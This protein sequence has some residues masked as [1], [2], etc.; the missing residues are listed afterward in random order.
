V[1]YDP[2]VPILEACPHRND[3]RA[4]IGE[5]P[6]AALRPAGLSPIPHR[7]SWPRPDI[8]PYRCFP[9]HRASRWGQMRADVGLFAKFGPEGAVELPYGCKGIRAP[10]MGMS[11]DLWEPAALAHE[12]FSRILYTN[13]RKLLAFTG[14]VFGYNPATNVRVFWS[15]ALTH[16]RQPKNDP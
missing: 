1:P 10:W 15:A 5:H 3:K 7:K 4:C 8:P 13:R 9:G 11:R 6:S 16:C 12:D 14:P 2:E